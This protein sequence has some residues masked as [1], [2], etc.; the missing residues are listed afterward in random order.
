[1]AGDWKEYQEEAAD[2]FRSLGL[3]AET[4]VTLKL[5]WKLRCHVQ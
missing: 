3:S 5:R 4:D 2:F 1:M